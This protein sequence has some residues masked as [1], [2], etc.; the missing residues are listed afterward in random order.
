MPNPLVSVLMTAYNREQYI[1]EAISSVLASTYTNFELIIL[2]DCSAD[3]TV[4]IAKSFAEKDPRIKLFVNDHNMGQFE[5]RNLAAKYAAGDLLKYLDSDDLLYP[6]GLE[7]LVRMMEKFPEAGYG[8]CSLEQDDARIFPFMLNPEEAFNRHFVQKI[9]LFHKAPLSSII[10]KQA[11][12]DV[13]GFTN[14]AGEGDYEMWLAL[15][16]KFNVVL[17]P[18]GVAWY[19]VHQGQIDFKRRTDP[20]LRF[21][22]YLVTLKYLGRD[23]PLGQAQIETVV[24][25]TRRIMARS[26]VSAFIRDSPAKAM[27]MYKAVRSKNI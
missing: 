21:R 14:P 7:V 10:R 19:R 6:T 8:L 27:Q 25:E 20:F 22:Y 24:K 17:M 16:S 15:S 11:F 12:F 9:P 13:G 5:N 23:C 26:M 3:R 1:G 4:E 18:H 2:D